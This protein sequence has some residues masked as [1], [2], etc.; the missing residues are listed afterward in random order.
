L[1]ENS[2]SSLIGTFGFMSGSEIDKFAGL[3]I[4][5]AKTGAPVVLDSAVAWFDCRMVSSMDTG[6]HLVIIGEVIESEVISEEQP[7][8]YSHYREKFRMLSPK[9]APTYIEKEKLDAEEPPAL[10][11]ENKQKPVNE[12]A[13]TP[14]EKE[15][16]EP[17]ICTICGFRYHPEEGDPAMG[18]PPGTPFEELPDDYRCPICNAGK[19]YFKKE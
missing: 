13:D 7:L 12:V 16:A 3:K 10:S 6:S 17:Y 2:S 5:T 11:V 9:N 1:K 8:T 18:I 19:E 15:L 14:D 4:V